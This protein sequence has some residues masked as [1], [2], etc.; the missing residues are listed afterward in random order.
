MQRTVLYVSKNRG[1]IINKHDF[2]HTGKDRISKSNNQINMLIISIHNIEYFC[3]KL[4]C[5][6]SLSPKPLK[7]NFVNIIHSIK[8]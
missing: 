7:S 1:D 5:G 4:I 8:D 6:K 2:Y 3:H